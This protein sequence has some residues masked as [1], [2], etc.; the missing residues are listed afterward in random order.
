[1]LT[2]DKKIIKMIHNYDP[3][4]MVEWD[5]ERCLWSMKRKSDDGRIFHLFF[6][7]NDDGSFRPLDERVMQLLYETDIWRHFKDAKDYHQFIQEKNKKHELKEKNIREEYLKWWNKDHK[8]E[9]KEAIEN[10][11]RGILSKPEEVKTKT[12]SIPKGENNESV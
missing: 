7:Q 12:Y 5:R 10:A 11:E 2:P 6:I 3:N 8:T 4:L 1:M 9:W